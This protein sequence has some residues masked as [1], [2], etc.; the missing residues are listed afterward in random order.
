MHFSEDGVPACVW[1]NPCELQNAYV[2]LQS[3]L[4]STHVTLKDAD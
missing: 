1:V 2:G 3:E 4:W